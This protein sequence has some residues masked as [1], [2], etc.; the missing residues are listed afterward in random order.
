MVLTDQLGSLRNPN[1]R[2]THRLL[3]LQLGEKRDKQLKEL[4]DQMAMKQPDGPRRDEGKKPFWE[5]DTFKFVAGM[6]MLV[7]MVLAKR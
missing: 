7:V 4:K 6:S 2:L 1:P 3:P 5:N